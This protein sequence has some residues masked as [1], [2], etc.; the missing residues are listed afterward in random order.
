MFTKEYLIGNARQKQTFCC[1]RC[2]FQAVV[3]CRL[4]EGMTGDVMERK[5]AVGKA[6][7]VRQVYC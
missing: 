5:R 2:L 7:P 4:A 1:G 3:Q 6:K